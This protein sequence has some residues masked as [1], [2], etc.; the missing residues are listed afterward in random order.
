MSILDFVGM[1]VPESLLLCLASLVLFLCLSSVGAIFICGRNLLVQAVAG[2]GLL[3]AVLVICV[4][5]AAAAA[6]YVIFG[7]LALSAA[8]MVFR[9]MTRRITFGDFLSALW[10]VAI[11]YGFFLV[12]FFLWIVPANGIIDFNCHTPYFFGISLEIFQAD[13]WSRLRIIDAY[14]FEWSKYHF[15]NGCMSAIPLA[16]FPDRNVVTYNYAHSL[17][18]S[19]F[20]AAIFSYLREKMTTKRAAAFF[21]AGSV[22]MFAG[23]FNMVTWSLFTNHWSSVL[24]MVLA[25]LMFWHGEH[26]E[27]GLVAM[28]LA[29]STSRTV[30]TGGL[31]F[32]WACVLLYRESGKDVRC[33]WGEQRSFLVYSILVGAGVLCMTL[34]GQMPEGG[35]VLSFNVFEN[36]FSDGWLCLIPNGAALLRIFGKPEGYGVAGEPLMILVYAYLILRNRAALAT[37][38]RRYQRKIVAVFSVVAAAMLLYAAYKVLGQGKAMNWSRLLKVA[39]LLVL[40]VLP[41]TSALLAADGQFRIPVRLF[42]IGA[43]AELAVLNAGV[44]IDNYSLIV[45]PVVLSFLFCMAEDFH[46]AWGRLAR[47]ATAI[48]LAVGCVCCCTYDYEMAFWGASWDH[49]HVYLPLAPVERSADPFVYHGPGDVDQA[50]LNAMRGNRVHY[51]VPLDREDKDLRMVTMSMHF[52]ITRP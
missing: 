35:S 38:C 34:S 42:L 14:P 47:S 44:S 7:V 15:F 31:F 6:K 17:A 30:L 24:L 40:Y 37:F 23:A 50:K 11:I 20:T 49:Y 41:V 16:V 2:A 8:G 3:A 46:Q 36:V 52:A 28:L 18:I 12:K 51:D 33:L 10:P 48:A 21:V 22:V 45:V 26:R 5:F 25:C 39:Q 9:L 13:Y 1:T 19:F 4:S 29:L 32:L 43:F 27:A